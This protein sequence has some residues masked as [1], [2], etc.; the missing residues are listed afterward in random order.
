MRNT[1][2]DPGQ[3]EKQRPP[4]DWVAEVFARLEIP[5]VAYVTKHLCGDYEAARDVVQET[6]VKLCQQAW[7]DI[8]AHSTAWMYR[9]CR[10]RAI[11]LNRREG[12]MS[13]T[14][15]GS[16]VAVL[17][18][19]HQSEPEA[20]AE[21]GEQ[22]ERVRSQ[23]QRLSDQQQEI[24]RLRLHDNLSYKQ[25]AEVTGLTVTNVGYHLHQA[26]AC[27]RAKVT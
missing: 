3:S 21:Q 1:E 23:L 24:L 11:D 2:S 5:L 12:L 20:I 18:D 8:E 27:L 14:I 22:I 25:I 19:H 17:P 9:T 6:F 13:K 26:I 10:N 4:R 7:P 16:D 15:S